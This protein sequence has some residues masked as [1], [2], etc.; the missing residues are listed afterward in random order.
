MRHAILLAAAAIG[1][2]LL[3]A[4]EGAALVPASEIPATPSPAVAK[5]LEGRTAG[6]PVSCV[7]LRQMRT[8][9]IIDETAVIYEES[10]SRWFVNFPQGGNCPN[11]TRDRAIATRTPS[12]QLC[13]GDL[14]RVFDQQTPIQYGSCSLGKFVPY[15]R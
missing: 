9:R 8:T 5:A 1:V 7:N 13:S 15:T 12:N 10:R 4:A 6:V 3:V 11:M 14:I 2:T